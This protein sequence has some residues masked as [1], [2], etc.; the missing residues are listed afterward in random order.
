MTTEGREKVGEE[1]DDEDLRKEEPET[2][3][4]TTCAESKMN[5]NYALK[6]MFNYIYHG[7][8]LSRPRWKSKFLTCLYMN[9]S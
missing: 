3:F 6:N 1:Y 2:L 4:N 5:S 7:S 8:R 9:I